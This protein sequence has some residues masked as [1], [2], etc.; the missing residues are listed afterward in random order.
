MLSCN[1]MMRTYPNAGESCTLLLYNLLVA[2]CRDCSSENTFHIHPKLGRGPL[3]LLKWFVE[4][5]M[6]LV[7]LLPSISRYQ[8]WFI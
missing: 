1:C 2:N 5:Y 4:G 6:M 3:P 7:I 8:Y